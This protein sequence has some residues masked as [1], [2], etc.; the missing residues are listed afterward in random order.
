MAPESSHQPSNQLSKST[1]TPKPKHQSIDQLS[2][3]KLAPK[4]QQ[5][6]HIL[7]SSLQ[8]PSSIEERSISS[9]KDQLLGICQ[10]PFSKHNQT[11]PPPSQDQNARTS[12]TAHIPTT[13]KSQTFV[14]H[15]SLSIYKSPVEPID[16]HT[17]PIKTTV[18]RSPLPTLERQP[19]PIEQLEKTHIIQKLL[20]TSTVH[21]DVFL[22]ESRVP[23][24]TPT[25]NA[26]LSVSQQAIL[27]L[28][29]ISPIAP[30]HNPP[31]YSKLSIAEP[32]VT[33]VLV[34]NEIQR[35]SH[36]ATLYSSFD[37]NKKQR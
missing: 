16:N 8:G 30:S 14:R 15:M 6:H 29:D 25:L 3:V 34:D 32:Q 27:N 10:D 13:S 7:P 2:K 28:Q 26:H 11:L 9:S 12:D 37:M 19:N 5:S 4:P 22:Q 35:A 20:N 1:L 36:I 31:P 17:N 18:L 21:K 24:D 33:K 23:N